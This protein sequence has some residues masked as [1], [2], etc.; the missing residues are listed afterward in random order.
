MA[1]AQFWRAEVA[2]EGSM[3]RAAGLIFTAL[4]AFGV[5]LGLLLR[6]WVPGQV[7]KFPLNEYSVTTLTGRGMTYFNST[8]LREFSNVQLTVTRTIEGN[9]TAGSSSTAV[10]ASFTALEDNTH[11]VAIQHASQ[12]SAFNRRTGLLVNCCG[13]SVGNDSRATQ[14]GQ[15][16][17]WPF[18]TQHRT[19]QVFDTTLLR[20]VP[21]EFAG[22]GTIDG[23]AADKFVE[24]IDN[25]RIGKQTLPGQFLA[26]PNRS[27][28]TLPE[29]LTA[30]NTYW[31][32]PVTG[33][34]VDII[35]NQHMTLRDA[36]G[37]NRLVL[38]SGTLAQTPASVRE[39]VASAR[40]S[41]R[42]I[43]WI[44]NFGPLIG[45]SAGLV[46]LIGGIV[47]LWRSV[48]AYQAAYDD[49]AED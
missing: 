42:M 33:I 40:S 17:R 32:D 36:A 23:I 15:G 3:R 47:L 4:G 21:F 1:A 31:V 41:H 38:L 19:Y 26:R 5:T 8:S 48:P 12:V 18:G 34:P 14:S 7:I 35:L 30:T 20:P 6:L 45:L 22:T 29:Y 49:E 16:F 27:T 39:A 10:W 25:L 37:K 44:Q 13:A 2:G 24:H 9:V 11:R 28:V 43:N 46:L